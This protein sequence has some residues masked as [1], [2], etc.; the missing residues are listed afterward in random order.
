[1]KKIISVLFALFVC[2]AVSAQQHMKFMGIPLD[3]TIENFTLKLKAKGIK[4]DAVLSKKLS[5]GSKLYKGTFMGE[6]ATFVVMFNAK[7]R[8]VFG[9]GVELSYSSL[10]LA[11]TPF[12]NIA[13]QLHTK[14]P[15]AIYNHTDKEDSNDD[16]GV[17]F[18]IPEDDS[19][20]L[21]GIIMQS[22]KRP[23]GILSPNFTIN[24]IY[25][26]IKNYKKHEAINNED[27]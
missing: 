20:E 24:L 12:I 23:E 4:Y 6:N 10:E 22:L 17:S 27:L 25:T 15:T 1:M 9:V 13:E 8:L 19:T 18:T 2:M 3:G 11:K 26:D 7:S 16:I 5:P 14:Y 21:L